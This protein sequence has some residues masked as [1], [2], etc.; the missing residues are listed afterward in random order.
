MKTLSLCT[1]FFLLIAFKSEAI[2]TYTAI[3]NGNWGNPSTWQKTNC[4][5]GTPNIPSDYSEI[6]IPSSITVTVNDMYDLFGAGIIVQGHLYFVSGKKIDLD[7]NSYLDVQPGGY[8]SGASNGSKIEYCDNGFVWTGNDPKNGPFL[9]GNLPIP[10]PVSLSKFN[11]GE[12]PTGIEL[13]WSTSSEQNNAYFEILH[14]YDALTWDYV[15]KIMGAGNSQVETRYSY[16]FPTEQKGIHYFRLKQT[17]TDGKATSSEIKSILFQY[18]TETE[19]YPNPANQITTLQFG[20]ANN[21]QIQL[22][23]T[24]GVLLENLESS[25]DTYHLQTAPYENGMYLLFI[26]GAFFTKLIIQH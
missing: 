14:S 4:A 13:N 3:Q 5:A 26:D 23:N 25:E 22:F 18:A 17:D 12:N 11:L 7:C 1:L 21:R 15:G 24:A 20:K 19:I 8:L 16:Y 6:I 9:I 10:L 2:C